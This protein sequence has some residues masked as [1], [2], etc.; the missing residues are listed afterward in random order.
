MKSA[1][2]VIDMQNDFV[3]PDAPAK[4]AGAYATIPRLFEILSYFRPS[5]FPVFH[6]IREYRKDGSDIG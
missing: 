3:L 2:V 6:V 1:L 5:N 4:V